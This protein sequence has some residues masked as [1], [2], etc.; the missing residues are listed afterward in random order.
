MFDKKD[1]DTVVGF[2]CVE[3]R[4]LEIEWR[5][6]IAPLKTV[7][8]RFSLNVADIF[9]WSVVLVRQE[10]YSLAIGTVTVGKVSQ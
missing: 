9:R 8:V 10:Y 7:R 3:E 4:S 6:H 1:R 2:P 5:R